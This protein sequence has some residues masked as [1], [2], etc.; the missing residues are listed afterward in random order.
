M[1]DLTIKKP[2]LRDHLSIVKGHLQHKSIFCYKVAL[3][4]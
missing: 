2:Y 4:V 1:K 3:D